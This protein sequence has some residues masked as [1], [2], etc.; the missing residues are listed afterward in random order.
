MSDTDDIMNQIP[1]QLRD[2]QI[3]LESLKRDVR[4][5]LPYAVGFFTFV[6]MWTVGIRASFPILLTGFT[7]LN[8]ALF[9]V[10][11]KLGWE[12]NK[13]IFGRLL[14]AQFAGFMVFYVTL[15]I[16]AFLLGLLLIG[17]TFGAP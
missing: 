11:R 16:Y 2:E 3:T 14:F 7:L 13:D 4:K 8:I 9:M 5:T 17:A 10:V 6:G 15:F 1:P 12:K